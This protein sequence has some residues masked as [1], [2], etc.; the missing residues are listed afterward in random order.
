[1]N[2]LKCDRCGGYFDERVDFNMFV[3]K[4]IRDNN[5][6]VAADLCPDCQSD[7][8]AFMAGAEVC[9]NVKVGEESKIGFA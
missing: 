8:E 5:R 3:G 4:K 7:L 1:M 6:F 2:A 9:A